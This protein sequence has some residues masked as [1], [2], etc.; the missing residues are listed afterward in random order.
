MIRKKNYDRKKWISPSLS[1]S[2]LTSIA[3]K[4]FFHRL[5]SL[6]PPLHRRFRL[7]DLKEEEEEKQILFF[8]SFFL[9]LSIYL[10]FCLFLFLFYFEGS[11]GIF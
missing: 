5:C 8:L 7:F 9:S 10:C 1:L 3:V 6:F 4:R 11:S 2:I